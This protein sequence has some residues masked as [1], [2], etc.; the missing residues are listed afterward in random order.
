MAAARLAATGERAD[1]NSRILHPIFARSPPA[2]N[3]L[4]A[5][6]SELVTAARQAL[7]IG[8]PGQAE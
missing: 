3:N 5:I 4:H 6:T 1:G 2:I 8:T 7:V